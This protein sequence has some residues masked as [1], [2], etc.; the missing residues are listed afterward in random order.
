RESCESGD[1]GGDGPQFKGIFLR[2]LAYLYDVPRKPAYYTFLY[3][4]AHAVWFNDR[5]VFSQLGLHWDGP[6]DSADASRQSSALIPASALAEP[7]T[8]DLSF[9]KGSGDPAFSHSI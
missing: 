3:K 6:W 2:Y 8:P 1:C 7:I 4:N 9:A 5:N